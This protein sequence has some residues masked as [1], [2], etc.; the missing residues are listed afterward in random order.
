[1][2]DGQPLSE[3]V[4]KH[5]ACGVRPSR[6]ELQDARETKS[7]GVSAF[8]FVGNALVGEKPGHLV[9]YRVLAQILTVG[10]RPPCFLLA[11]SVLAPTS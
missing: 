7:V 1:M 2:G 6:D 5:G 10:Y 8:L 9:A 11:P 4:A 3:T